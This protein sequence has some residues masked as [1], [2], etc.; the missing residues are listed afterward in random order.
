MH[1][2]FAV[3]VAFVKTALFCLAMLVVMAVAALIVD[4]IAAKVTGRGENE[5]G[6]FKKTL[7]VI[8]VLTF[9]AVFPSQ[10]NHYTSTAYLEDQ[11][12]QVIDR[13]D[14]LLK[15]YKINF[16]MTWGY[17]KKNVMMAEEYLEYYDHVWGDLQE[18]LGDGI[19]FD[20]LTKYEM[21]LVNYPH[22]GSR[23]CIAKGGKTY[24]ST[25]KCYTL[26]K[27]KVKVWVDA[28]QK[29]KYSPCSKCV[30]D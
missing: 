25:E 7:V 22:V 4:W 23:I 12:E 30:G 13:S 9:V 8:F 5:T 19:P 21:S 16:P 2:F 17:I 10:Y 28:S 14:G 15:Y 11:L 20:T 29:W 6:I 1:P 26:I 27:T 3:L 18:Y 24:H